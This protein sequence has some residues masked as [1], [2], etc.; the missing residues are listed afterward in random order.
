[1]KLRTLILIASGVYRF[2]GTVALIVIGNYVHPIFV[3][4]SVL[5]LVASRR[6]IRQWLLPPLFSSVTCPNC[7]R[8]ISLRNRWKCKADQW[9]DSRTRHALAVYSD[10]GHEVRSFDCR[11]CES[12]ISLQKG[13]KELYRRWK[14]MD[15]FTTD[16]VRLSKR[17]VFGLH[18]GY[19]LHPTTGLLERMWRLIRRK[20][21]TAPIVISNDVLARHGTIFGATGM[22]KSTLIISLARQIFERGDGATFLDPAGDLSRDLIR[23]VPPKRLNDV[24]YIDVSDQEFPFPFNILHAA[25][26][27]ERGQLIDEVLNIFK[28]IYSKEWGGTLDHQLR[29][30]LNAIVEMR[31]SFADV[32]DLFSNPEAR[33]GIVRKIKTKELRDYWENTFPGSSPTSR[34][35]IINTLQP[36]VKHPF[37]G[38]ILSS[39]RCAFDADDVIGNRK[40]LI[41]NLSTGSPAP[42]TAEI[43]GTLIVNKIRAAAYRQGAIKDK[44]LRVRHFL[45]VDEFQNFMHKASG[46]ER[47]LSE[48]RKFKLCLILVTQF[49]EQITDNIRA[50]IF[51]NVGFLIAFRVGYRDSKILTDEFEGT[52][53]QDLLDLQRGECFVRMGT[54][55]LAV[56]TELPP[57]PPEYDPDDPPPERQITDRMHEL[58]TELRKDEPA[59]R[60]E[61]D[62]SEPPGGSSKESTATDLSQKNEPVVLADFA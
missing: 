29:M 13:D 3:A 51:G 54:E 33:Q 17:P 8:R 44:E 20:P 18:I 55:S 50:A 40:I 15:S 5:W 46:W 14:P 53:K 9:T 48:V 25:D 62:P 32:Y 26:S 41:V 47:S 58:I 43:L 23:Q 35:S 7:R 61:K 16:S 34:M 21:A 52:T 36:I 4:L 12:T 31:G 60:D 59:F 1:M 27:N 28:S 49:V 39:R 6:I 30:A 11:H 42:Y 38:P 24:L 56:R 37:L 57:G 22:G 2:G 45:C 19:D 10:Q